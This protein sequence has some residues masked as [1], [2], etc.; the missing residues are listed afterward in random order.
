M[1]E[2][3]TPPSLFETDEGEHETH[4]VIPAT[5]GNLLQKWPSSLRGYHSAAAHV[6]K[7]L[8]RLARARVKDRR[9]EDVVHLVS[10]LRRL[11]SEIEVDAG[12]VEP[13]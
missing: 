12:P 7:E 4:M 1:A 5:K 2:P 3:V 9:V 10:R 11:A 8:G 13:G 6:A